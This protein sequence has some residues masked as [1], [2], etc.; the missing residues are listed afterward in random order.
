MSCLR[1]QLGFSAPR[2]EPC[3]LELREHLQQLI[4]GVSDRP[5]MRVGTEVL[6][7]FTTLTAYHLRSWKLFGDGHRQIRVGLVIAI[8][9]IETRVMKFDPAVLQLERF[10]FGADD[11][12]VHPISSGHHGPGP[13]MQG[14]DIGEIGREAAPQVA[15]LADIQNPARFI[16]EAIDPWRGRHAARRRTRAGDLSVF[17]H[18]DRLGENHRAT[19]HTNGHFR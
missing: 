16:E 17:S 13:R 4:E 14:R 12:P 6:D 1:G 11:R 10:S 2:E 7:A 5:R 15:G 9:H 8:L 3:P 19:L 18:G